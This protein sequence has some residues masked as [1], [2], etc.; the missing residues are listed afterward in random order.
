[1]SK[2][3]LN[4]AETVKFLQSLALKDN[5]LNI[6]ALVKISKNSIK[7]L[8]LSENSTVGIRS[9]LAHSE[10]TKDIV[11][12]IKNLEEFIKYVNT[13]DEKFVLSIQNNQFNLTS[14]SSKIAGVFKA[15]EYVRTSKIN[16]GSVEKREFDDNIFD[17]K[18][19]SYNDGISIS[20]SAETVKEI[21]SK[22]KIVKSKS[23]SFVGSKNS[24]IVL[25][26]NKQEEVL[27]ELK[28]DAEGTQE[29]KFTVDEFF[30]SILETINDAVQI[31]YNKENSQIALNVDNKN[32]KIEYLIAL[33]YESTE[34]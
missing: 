34:N 22:H 14:K 8:L 4:K 10:N 1:M 17:E 25:M 27:L 18:L 29:Y 5:A 20:L 23:L 33:K 32:L 12:G 7:S 16:D 21:V 30:I 26:E 13:M 15:P 31:R 28:F 24:I 19:S 2:I 9:E 11:F 6:D 3:T